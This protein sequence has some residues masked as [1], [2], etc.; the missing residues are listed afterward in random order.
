MA[1][2]K[3]PSFLRWRAKV[4]SL[5]GRYG[6][7]SG[8]GFVFTPDGFILTNS[9]VVDRAQEL[10]INLADGY[11]LK[12][13]VTGTD[14]DTD[15][16]VAKTDASGLKTVTLGDS[17]SLKVG[18]VAIAIGN[19]HGFQISVTSG[20]VNALGRSFRSQTGRLMEG[21]IQ[22]DGALNP[23]NSGG[24][25]VNMHHEVIGGKHGYDPVCSGNKVCHCRQHCVIY[26]LSADSIRAGAHEV[27]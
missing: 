25:L 9:H 17:S 21:V 13:T 12:A 19:P 1:E 3:L 22:T 27:L 24:P 18:Q 20:I 5:R 10:H 2:L 4:V 16:A 11:R 14:P 8:S 26:S 7:G 15:L 23:G 6:E